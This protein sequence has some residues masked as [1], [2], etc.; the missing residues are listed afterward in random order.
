M[1]PRRYKGSKKI[2]YNI[3]DR[4]IVEKRTDMTVTLDSKLEYECFK[5]LEKHFES[6]TI[7]VHCLARIFK[8]IDPYFG[9]VNWKIDFRVPLSYKQP[10]MWIECK[11]IFDGETKLKTLLLAQNSPSI[12]ES[13]IFVHSD[14]ATIPRW[15]ENMTLVPFSRL[16][17]Y[18]GN[19][20]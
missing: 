5:I 19:L 17:R 8:G 2:F 14:R 1:K 15:T 11:G 9:A 4:K 7:D 13:L 16:D 10:P 3:Q 6:T 18:L 20:T 12:F